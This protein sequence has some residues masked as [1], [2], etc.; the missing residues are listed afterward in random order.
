MA[1]Y[2]PTPT[3]LFISCEGTSSERY[4]FEAIQEEIQDKEQFELRIYPN[5]NDPNPKTTPR[6]M[7]AIARRYNVAQQYDKLWAVYDKN[8]YTKHKE[9]LELAQKPN[10]QKVHIAFSSIAFEH[11]LL[12]HFERSSTAFPKSKNVIEQLKKYLP[13]YGKDATYTKLY[14]FEHTK[15]H[16]PTAFKNAAWLRHQQKPLLTNHPIYTI[17]PYTDIDRL[18]QCLLD[19]PTKYQFID[20]NEA[21]PIG[22][23][24]FYVQQ[25]QAHLQIAVRNDGKTTVKM[26]LIQLKGF[27][28]AQLQATEWVWS[29]PFVRP[30]AVATTEIPLQALTH[31]D[32][33]YQNTEL[34]LVLSPLN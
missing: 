34:T 31:L 24:M 29:A 14:L 11:W 1:K 16:L 33:H 2:A 23:L 17:N 6:E 27:E 28:K 3:T 15:Q 4:Y 9:A 25:D 18:V 8:G 21:V 10:V 5:D 26:D 32:I 12:L 22:T 20:L 13:K 7:I 19:F 30:E